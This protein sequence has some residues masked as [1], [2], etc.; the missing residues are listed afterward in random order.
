MKFS[1]L[2]SE[3]I[4][5]L[6]RA[7]ARSFGLTLRFLPK[8][9]RE[10]LSL[11]YLLARASDTI[12]D[13]KGIERVRRLEL[14]SELKKI[15]EKGISLH[16]KPEFKVK[17]IS[18]SEQGLVEALPMLFDLLEQSGDRDELLR[19]WQRILKGQIFDLQRF[20]GNIQPLSQSE[21]EEY[22]YLVAGSVGET[23]TKLIAFHSP[24]TL[25]SSKEELIQLGVSY[26]KGL[27]LLNILRDREADRELVRIYVAEADVRQMLDQTAAWLS[28]GEKYCARLHPGRIRYSTEIPLRLATRTLTHLR[29]KPRATRVKIPRAEVYRVLVQ[30]LPSL[31]LRSSWNP[32]S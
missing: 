12:A 29:Q 14:L 22:C 11:G 6:L 24:Q 26:G 21:L 31:V 28:E 25:L 7:H 27:Q 3:Q 18:E 9:L 8:K 30:T 20:D 10:S 17:M 1:V 19:L 5:R 15:L 4:R 32:D 23:W 2:T 13:A 16:W